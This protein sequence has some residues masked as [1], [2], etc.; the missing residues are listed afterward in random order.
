MEPTQRLRASA[1]WPTHDITVVSTWHCQCGKKI[2]VDAAG[3]AKYIEDV[4]T[5]E[6]TK[7]MTYGKE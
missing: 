5:G 4:V 7:L 6:L 3:M 1:G 2:H